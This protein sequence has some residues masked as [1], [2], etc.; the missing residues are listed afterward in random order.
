MGIAITCR[1]VALSDD[2]KQHAQDKAE[3]L[4]EKFPRIENVHVILDQQR[5]QK[6]AEV[7]AQGKNHLHLEAAADAD[8]I[9]EAIDGAI[10]RITKQLSKARSKVQSHRTRATPEE[11]EI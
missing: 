6:L 4:V 10:S 1:H 5:H 9:R 3:R 7:V 11:P 2:A 8:T